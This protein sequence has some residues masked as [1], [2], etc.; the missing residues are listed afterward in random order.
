MKVD[1][2][3]MKNFSEHKKQSE[4]INK[5]YKPL[6]YKQA[7]YQESIESTELSREKI[8]QLYGI[9]S[10]IVE[11]N[12]NMENK[13]KFLNYITNSS[14]Y[15]CNAITINFTSNYYVLLFVDPNKND[16]HKNK[17]YHLGNDS[18]F[19][20]SGRI[21]DMYPNIKF[22]SILNVDDGILLLESIE[23]RKII[24]KFVKSIA[25]TMYKGK[26]IIREFIK[27][28]KNDDNSLFNKK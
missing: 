27:F 11:V 8:L 13:T 14:M 26:K 18:N 25:N 9:D 10:I 24:R 19:V 22:S 4:Y 2:Y 7:I 23:N 3:I 20:N 1:D 5:K 6:S 16:I 21:Y 28:N 15:D 12:N 17:L